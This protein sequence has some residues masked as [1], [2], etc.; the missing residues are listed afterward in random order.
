MKFLNA[1]ACLLLG[2]F[3]VAA[4]PRAQT[5]EFSTAGGG[6]VA[7][8]VAR[9]DYL[10]VASGVTVG[11]WDMHDPAHPVFAG[12]TA[13]AVGVIDSLVEVGGY[14]YAA[15]SRADA[16]AGITIY[17]LDAPAQ[18]VV[19]GEFDDYVQ[20][21]FK[22]PLGLAA[23]GSHVYLGDSQ[24]GLFVLD[25]AQPLAPAVLGQVEGA[26]VFDSMAV[27]GTQLLASGNSFLGGRIVDVIDITDPAAPV[28]AGSTSLDGT[29]V[30]RAALTDG[31]A[32]GVGNDLMVYD[33]HD[34][35]NITQIFDAPI[36]QATGAIRDGDTLYLVGDSGIQVWDFAT[37]SA[38]ALLR[39]VPAPT[40]APDRTALTA[41]GPLILT[42][43]DRGVLLGTD[44]P[45]TPTVA[46]QFTLPIGVAAKAVAFDGDNVYF[47]EEGYGLASADAHS[48][49]PI[50]RFDADLP[51][52]LAARDFE[53]ISL[54]SGRAYL[55]AWGYGVIIADLTDPAAPTELGRFPFFAATAIEAHGD[56]LYVGSTTNGGVF[57]VLDVSNP[58]QPTELGALLTS[59]TYDLTVRGDYAYLADGADFGDGGLRVVDVSDAANP[60]VVGQEMSCPYAN[61]LD[62]SADGNTTYI[63]C[64]DGSLRIVDTTDRSAP[65]EIGS[66]TLP[67]VPSLPDYNSAHSVVV[68]GGIA[69][70]GNEYGVDEVDVSVPDAPVAG[71]RHETGFFVGQVERAP[72]GR[73]FALAQVAGTYVFAPNSDTVF[74]NGFD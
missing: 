29:R 58:A 37:P 51:P 21:D 44:D 41:F 69:Y 15:W 38:P 12:R 5:L 74:A 1:A 73:L 31:Y 22:G 42:H 40:F 10:Y 52:S 11:V 70:V 20:A 14:L 4:A 57:R 32:I 2:A 26:Y 50:G 13:P 72:D 55:A 16:T 54:D 71:V 67:G 59:K 49:A 43:T 7:P 64:S 25:A 66:V 46:A 65:Q 28:L 3:A 9:G 62:V 63:A 23:A 45:Q 53:G 19:A 24:N 61:G 68:S 36:D 27:F 17:S 33:L 34:P 60:A 6:A 18:P 39:T 56:R 48:L 35:A 47:A 30:L 8:P